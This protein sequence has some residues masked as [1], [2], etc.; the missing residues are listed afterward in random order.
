LILDQGGGISLAN[1]QTY[2]LNEFEQFG[3]ALANQGLTEK[4]AKSAN[5]SA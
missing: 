3:I 4:V 1:C 2:L 5:I